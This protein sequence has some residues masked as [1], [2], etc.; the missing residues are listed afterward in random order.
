MKALEKLKDMEEV[1]IV[2]FFNEDIV[3]HPI[4]GKIINRW[5]K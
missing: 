4:I 5:K 3:R 1:D 2:E